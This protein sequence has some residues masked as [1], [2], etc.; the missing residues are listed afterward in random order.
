MK[1]KIFT[2]LTCLALCLVTIFCSGCFNCLDQK[3]KKEFVEAVKKQKPIADSFV[4]EITDYIL[5][6]RP[7]TY[8]E[9][10]EDMRAQGFSRYSDFLKNR[11]DTSGRRLFF[12]DVYD[13]DNEETLVVDFRTRRLGIDD[14]D[15]I[16]KSFYTKKSELIGFNFFVYDVYEYDFSLCIVICYDNK[17]FTINNSC[18]NGDIGRSDEERTRPTAL[19]MVDLENERLIYCGYSIT[20]FEN[21][22]AKGS[23][24]HDARELCLKISK[25]EQE[26][27]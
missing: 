27:K 24:I 11:T 12:V 5:E 18:Y 17:Y 26:G 9:S 13:S 23:P 10:E 20:H 14:K 1:S 2:K 7:L 4:P 22:Y 15:T 8:F 6:T 19:Y 21:L 16:V 25:R 3:H